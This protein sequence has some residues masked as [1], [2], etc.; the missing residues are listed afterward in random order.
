M[1][2]TVLHES[3]GRLRVRLVPGGMT[4]EEADLLE[5]ALAPLPGVRSAKIYDR[6]GDAVITF[7]AGREE[8]LRTLAGFSF[9]AARI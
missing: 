1:K 4:L 5:A 2:C 6:T 8:I 3:S 9:G 7:T